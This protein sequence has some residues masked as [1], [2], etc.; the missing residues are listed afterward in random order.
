MSA[1]AP[2]HPKPLR[3]GIIGTGL[4]ALPVLAGSAAYAI[5]ELRGWRIGLERKPQEASAFYGVLALA[6]LL[7]LT[8]LF[9]PID[10]IKARKPVTALVPEL[11]DNLRPD[12]AR[13]RFAAI[14]QA[15]VIGVD[16]AKHLWVGE[17]YVRRVLDEI[18]RIVAP[19]KLPEGGLPTEVDASLVV[20]G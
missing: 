3:H 14:P 10:P 12:E 18:V 19:S 8:M 13:E 17:K 20:E 4:L 15:D 1:S 16:G 5:G 9:L 2:A 6:F 11:D 7:G